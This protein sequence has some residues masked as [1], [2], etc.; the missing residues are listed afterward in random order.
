MQTSALSLQQI[1]A[2]ASSAPNKQA[3][4][5]Q[6]L[7]DHLKL[8]GP[9]AK[10]QVISILLSKLSQIKEDIGTLPIDDKMK[11][12]LNN[13][14]SPFSGILNLSHIHMNIDNAKNNFLKGDHLIGL[15][16]VHLAL[17]GH[18]SRDNIERE[19][20]ESLAESFRSLAV[21]IKNERLPESLKHSILKRTLKMAS[22]LDHYYAFG[23]DDL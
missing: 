5:L 8:Q 23:P 17:T 10:T 21:K 3:N 7:A 6:V 4:F 19:E 12:H 18:V 14:L 22:I 11:N 9:D 2:V 15:T 20:A 16:N 13:Q 1:L